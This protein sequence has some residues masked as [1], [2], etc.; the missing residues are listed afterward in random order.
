MV[1][2]GEPYVGFAPAGQASH[3]SWAMAAIVVE[4]LPDPHLTQLSSA[5]LPVTLRKEPATQGLHSVCPTSSIYVP[6]G[7]TLHSSPSMVYSDDTEPHAKCHTTN[8]SDR[9]APYFPRMS[10]GVCD[11]TR[12]RYW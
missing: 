10:A 12:I 9:P 5:M 4:N 3:V 2:E 7:H 8:T 1:R 11:G 6:A